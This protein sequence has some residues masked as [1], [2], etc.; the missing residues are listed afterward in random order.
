[1]VNIKLDPEGIHE[2]VGLYD[3]RAAI[4]THGAELFVNS[5][6]VLDTKLLGTDAALGRF[7]AATS[8][9]AGA[10]GWGN[11]AGGVHPS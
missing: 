7:L 9:W 5:V 1:L 6:D 3:V 11:Y 10:R 8:P 4:V 2:L